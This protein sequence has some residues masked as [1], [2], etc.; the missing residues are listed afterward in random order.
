MLDSKAKRFAV[1]TC[2]GIL[3]FFEMCEEEPNN[4]TNWEKWRRVIFLQMGNFIQGSPWQP[5]WLSPYILNLTEKNDM[6]AFEFLKTKKGRRLKR[7]HH[8]IQHPFTLQLVRSFGVQ[9]D[10]GRDGSLAKVKDDTSSDRRPFLRSYG[11][12]ALSLTKE[13]DFQ[14]N[15][16]RF[17][18]I[19]SKNQAISIFDR[20]KLQSSAAPKKIMIPNRY[21]EA[22][23]KTVGETA[24][25]GGGY[26]TG[27]EN[28]TGG[29]NIKTGSRTGRFAGTIPDQRLSMFYGGCRLL[30]ASES[31]L[32]SCMVPVRRC[33]SCDD[34]H[35]S[36]YRQKMETLHDKMVISSWDPVIVAGSLT[37]S[38]MQ[39]AKKVLHLNPFY[40]HPPCPSRQDHTFEQ[41]Y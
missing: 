14:K 5:V 31:L 13:N 38:E 20:R 17:Q 29:G 16:K 7:K 35:L 9:T 25:K 41:V 37:A 8:F 12:Q 19:V 40:T 6:P 18:D 1:C 22:K 27:G 3:M 32:K 23:Y 36:R 2:V 10:D 39:I 28:L 21:K 30:H 11:K 34:L 4:V 24:L 15:L 26:L 33:C